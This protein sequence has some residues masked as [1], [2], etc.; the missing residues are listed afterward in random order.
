MKTKATDTLTITPTHSARRIDNIGE[1]RYIL[2]L[3]CDQ[4][5]IFFTRSYPISFI[6]GWLQSLRIA[7][8]LYR[9][10]NV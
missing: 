10:P 1:K 9:R 6:F 2:W 4:L 7:L 3:F 5:F 8:R